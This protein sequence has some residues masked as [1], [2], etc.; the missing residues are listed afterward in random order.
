[1]L[2]SKRFEILEESPVNKDGFVIEWPEM[3][4]SCQK[5][6]THACKSVGSP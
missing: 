6:W 3:G 1:M 4:C 5:N 2:R